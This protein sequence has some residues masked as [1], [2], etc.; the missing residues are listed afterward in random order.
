MKNYFW[1]LPSMTPFVAYVRKKTW[2]MVLAQPI[3]L[4]DECTEKNRDLLACLN[5]LCATATL[6][7]KT[8]ARALTL[9][10]QLRPVLLQSALFTAEF[11]PPEDVAAA[12]RS[13]GIP[14]SPLLPCLPCECSVGATSFIQRNFTPCLFA[15]LW[16]Y[17]FSQLS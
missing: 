14:A 15:M 10:A 3:Q 2:K 12:Q 8:P 16:Q 6:H 7:L 17:I 9:E 4:P 13:K 1:Q 11:H 5:H